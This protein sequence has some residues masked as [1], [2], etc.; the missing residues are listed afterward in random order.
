MN[1]QFNRVMISCAK[2]AG[3]QSGLLLSSS[4]APRSHPACQ[5]SAGI[6]DPET[7]ALQNQLLAGPAGAPAPSLAG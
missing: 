1:G 4:T 2:D 3:S 5:S 7:T 6:N